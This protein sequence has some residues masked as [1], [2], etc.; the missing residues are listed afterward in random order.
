MDWTDD[1]CLILIDLFKDQFY[2]IR[3]IA[4]IRWQKK[5]D[6]WSEIAKEMN[7]NVNEVKRKMDS[8]QASYRRERRIEEGTSRYGAGSDEVFRSKWYA[9]KP[10]QFL[11]DKFLSRNTR[12]TIA[13]S[14]FNFKLLLS[15]YSFF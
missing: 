5:I 15:N 3:L 2:G 11:K 1:E 4:N 9:F 7:R 13:V 6:Y 14:T 12:D 10:M 8:L